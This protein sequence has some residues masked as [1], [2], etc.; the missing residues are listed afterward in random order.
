MSYKIRS[1][2]INNKPLIVDLESGILEALLTK[3]CSYSVIR[4]SKTIEEKITDV[5]RVIS[6]LLAVLLNTGK[7]ETEDL[8]SILGFE[9]K[10]NGELVKDW[11]QDW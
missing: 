8:S 11:P 4:D 9:C 6:R 5:S 3:E 1:K 10:L 7:I 2:T